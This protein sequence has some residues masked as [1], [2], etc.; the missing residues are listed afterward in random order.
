[1]EEERKTCIGRFIFREKN[2]TTSPTSYLKA[3]KSVWRPMQ[4]GVAH[5][6]SKI[7]WALDLIGF[8]SSS[9]LH[10]LSLLGWVVF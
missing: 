1:M 2:N 5:V 4:F 9:A 7:A 6:F 3:S 10:F 8:K